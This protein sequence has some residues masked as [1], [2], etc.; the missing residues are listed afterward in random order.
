[1]HYYFCLLS[2]SRSKNQI[3]LETY[4]V[5][6]CV[7]GVVTYSNKILRLPGNWGFSMWHDM[8]KQVMKCDIWVCF[9]C[10]DKKRLL[11]AGDHSILFRWV[12]NIPDSTASITSHVRLFHREYNSKVVSNNLLLWISH[13]W[14]SM[15]PIKTEEIR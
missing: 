1:M 11:C 10:T 14:M 7:S 15:F 13:Y 12:L 4:L 5:W 6:W 3:N 9:Y 8:A 2:V